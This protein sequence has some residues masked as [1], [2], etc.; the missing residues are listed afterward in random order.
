MQ[1]VNYFQMVQQL[2]DIVNVFAKNGCTYSQ[3]CTVSYFCN[4]TLLCDFFIITVILQVLYF[5]VII[6][7]SFNISVFFLHT[8]YVHVI[9]SVNCS[10]VIS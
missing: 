7:H 2:R 1:D 8:V 9:V 3:L 10:V 5:A 6:C 4:L